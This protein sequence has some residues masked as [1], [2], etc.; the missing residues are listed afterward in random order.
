MLAK[1]VADSLTWI[2]SRSMFTCGYTAAA[3]L[4]RPF[5][6]PATDHGGK[7]RSP[8]GRDLRHSKALEIAS[9]RDGG[10]QGDLS[11]RDGAVCVTGRAT[12]AQIGPSRVWRARQRQHR[13]PRRRIPAVLFA[14]INFRSGYSVRAAL[15]VPGGGRSR[16]GHVRIERSPWFRLCRIL[17]SLG[18]WTIWL[19]SWFTASINALF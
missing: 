8:S 9:V 14:T 16:H 5:A 19:E 4:H 11:L 17:D 18:R 10:E 12:P 3:C 15:N 13:S 6:E 2:S 1:I 7:V